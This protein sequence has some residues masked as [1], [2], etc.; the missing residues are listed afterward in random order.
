MSDAA[1]TPQSNEQH[2]ADE[3]TETAMKDSS[4]WDGKLRVDR[5]AVLTNPE[6]VEDPDHTDDE[7]PP[8]EEIDADE[9][10]LSCSLR[11]KKKKGG[12]L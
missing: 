8:V 11:K 5:H 9:G 7:A 3:T 12:R 6:A 1:P 10:V 2:P 4:G